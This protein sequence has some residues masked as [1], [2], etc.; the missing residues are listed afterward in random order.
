MSEPKPSATKGNKL[1]DEERLLRLRV[2]AL[3]DRV[4]ALEARPQVGTTVVCPCPCHTGHNI[5]TLPPWTITY[6]T[7]TGGEK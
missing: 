1:N 3:E 4:R 5:P 6:G 7:N 2:T